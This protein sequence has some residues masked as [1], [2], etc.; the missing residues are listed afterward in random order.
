MSRGYHRY[1]DQA[2]G[3][4]YSTEQADAALTQIKAEH[5]GS[6]VP[7]LYDRALIR[8]TTGPLA[9]GQRLDAARILADRGLPTDHPA[10]DVVA[11]LLGQMGLSVDAAG[12]PTRTSTTPPVTDN[13]GLDPLAGAFGGLIATGWIGQ[14]P[15]G[16]DLA[17]LYLTSP[18]D[19]VSR[20]PLAQAMATV[21]TALGLN[22]APGSLTEH[23]TAGVRVEIEERFAQ[24]L[25]GGQR[26][27]QY[28]V[29]TDWITA[30]TTA[31][32]IALVLSYLPMPSGTD[33]ASHYDRSMDT[34]RFTVGLIPLAPA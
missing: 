7:D 14:G 12:R 31:G 16:A 5:P 34:G 25:V 11:G 8:L 21:A 17:Y 27:V 29:S 10:A 28:P 30:A 13:P 33:P 32:R 9:T 24:L 6:H 18:G 1:L 20:T 3:L 26:P 2:T 4:G 23:P 19:G 22:P 15:D